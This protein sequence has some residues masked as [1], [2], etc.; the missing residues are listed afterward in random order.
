MSPFTKL[1]HSE[2]LTTG[3]N[4]IYICSF[5]LKPLKCNWNVDE[6]PAWWAF[7]FLLDEWSVQV[8]WK[9][10]Q[11]WACYQ[12]VNVTHAMCAIMVLYF[13]YWSTA[14]S[15][16][17]PIS[18]ATTITFSPQ[19]ICP[20]Q[21]WGNRA[22]SITQRIR[23]DVWSH[24]SVQYHLIVLGLKYEISLQICPEETGMLCERRRQRTKLMWI[25]HSPA[26]GEEKKKANSGLRR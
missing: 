1:A 23:T 11:V 21:A 12:Q 3:I 14:D 10:M 24:A 5:A 8:T 19:L 13:I 9:D 25:Q 20:H 2:C 4:P 6:P 17:G 18:E 7:D 26:G 16:C 22:S 15:F